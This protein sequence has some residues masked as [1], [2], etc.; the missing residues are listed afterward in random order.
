VCPAVDTTARQ[1]PQHVEALIEA[2]A[3]LVKYMA[4]RLAGRLPAS[5]GVED[6]ISTGVLGLL[7]AI[8]KYDPQRP[9]TFKTYAEFRIRGAMLDYVREVDWVP[10]SVRDKAQAL[11]KAYAALAHQQGRPATDEDV[12]AWLGLDLATLDEW[13]TQVRG[14]S[15]VSLD[16]P[17]APDAEGDAFA[18]MAQLAD[19]APSPSQLTE[20]QELQQLL[21]EAIDA[22]PEQEKVVLALYYHEELTM[23]EIG[24]VLGVTESRISQIRTKAMFHLR[25]AVQHLTHDAYAPVG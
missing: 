16:Q 25:A 1:A 22:L 2:Y 24:A 8:Q 10:R 15:V 19:E 17:L 9:N 20:A 18:A 5:I 13:L 21:A 12:A 11:T 23:Q 6:L 14:V 7:D 3:P 4:H